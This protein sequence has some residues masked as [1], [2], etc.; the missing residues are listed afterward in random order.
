MVWIVLLLIALMCVASV[1][2]RPATRIRI[3]NMP[4]TMNLRERVKLTAVADGTVDSTTL[5]FVEDSL[6][7]MELIP[8]EPLSVWFYPLA[9]GVSQPVLLLTSTN[10]VVLKDQALITIVDPAAENMHI[11]YGTPERF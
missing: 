2:K 7:R 9:V 3:K 10:G 5:A 4:V 8:E 11:E 6:G 1:G